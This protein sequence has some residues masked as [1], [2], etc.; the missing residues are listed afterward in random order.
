MYLKSCSVLLYS[1]HLINNY[2]WT[3]CNIFLV[4]VRITY[5]YILIKLRKLNDNQPEATFF[6]S[7]RKITPHPCFKNRTS[8][9]KQQ[10]QLLYKDII[11]NI[12]PYESLFCAKNASFC[13][14]TFRLQYYTMIIYV[15]DSKSHF[16]GRNIQSLRPWTAPRHCP[17]LKT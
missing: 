13:A 14:L 4:L 1:C 17:V 6:A 7:L 5:M 10:L 8:Q 15:E 12:G 9:W 2:V 3:Y 11:S 16:F